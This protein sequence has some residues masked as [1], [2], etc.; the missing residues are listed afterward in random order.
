MKS[1]HMLQ[2]ERQLPTPAQT[3]QMITSTDTFGTQIYKK[4]G[5]PRS[6]S[7]QAQSVGRV[8]QEDVV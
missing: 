6:Q 3:S 8:R 2:T 5:F 7:P 1:C 4:N